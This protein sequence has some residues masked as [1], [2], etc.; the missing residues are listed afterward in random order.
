MHS[1]TRYLIDRLKGVKLG[2]VAEVGVFKGDNAFGLMSNLD[3]G[4]FIGVD[5]Y[6]RYPEFQNYL[7][8]RGVVARADLKVVKR[9]MLLKMKPFG[10]RF[11]LLQEYSVVAAAQYENESFD[12]VF[13]DGNHTKKYVLTDIEEWFPKVKVGGVIAGHGYIDRPKYGVIEA[14]NELLPDHEHSKKGA[15][16]WWYRKGTGNEFFWHKY[17]FD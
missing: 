7:R 2:M 15:N 13:I 14:G 1:H 16:V 11:M 9:D 10:S 3:I 8:Q 5:P 12:F 6:E 17:K 4:L